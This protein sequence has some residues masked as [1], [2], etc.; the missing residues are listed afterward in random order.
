MKQRILSII[1]ALL[2]LSSASGQV[3]FSG[4]GL[5]PVIEVAPEASTGLNKIYVVYNTDG[6]GMTYTATSSDPVVWLSYDSHNW[7][8]PDTITDIRQDGLVTT[9]DQ[10]MPNRGYII[11]EGTAATC[12]WVVNYADYK[13]ELNDIIVNKDD[14][15]SLLSFTVDGH[16][17][18]IPYY[19]TDGRRQVL[20]REIELHYNTLVWDGLFAWYDDA[21]HS[22][23]EKEVVETFASL[24]EAITI[25][26]PLCGTEFAF[27]GDRF[28]LEWGLDEVIESEYYD[29]QAVACGTTATGDNIE[30][31][32]DDGQLG[33]PAPIS[34]TFT[35]YPTDA[36]ASGVWEMATDSDFEN[37]IM[38]FPQDEVT[39]RFT[40]VGIYYYMRY[41]VANA[42][43]SCK[44][45]SDTYTI[46]PRN[47]D[48]PGD[49]NGDY[50]VNLVDINATIDI[51]LGRGYYTTADV[52]CDGEIN[53]ADVNAIVKIILHN[54]Y[55]DVESEWVDLGLPSGT[56]WATCNIGANYPEESGDYFAWGETAP[57]EVYSWETYKWAY[58]DSDDEYV[59]TKYNYDSR[60]G[61]VDNKMVLDPEDDAAYV[62]LGPSWRMPSAEQIQELTRCCAWRWRSRD[63]VYGWLGTG[64]NGKNIFLPV[65]GYRDEDSLRHVGSYGYCWSSDIR[66]EYTPD[67]AHSLTFG[68]GPN[69]WDYEYG[70][71]GLMYDDRSFGFTIRPVRVGTE[72]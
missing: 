68:W 38:Q 65:T 59:L 28:L 25:D 3:A 64:P 31:G 22:W 44:A 52:N 57:K 32:F 55:V 19:A 60:Y 17:D 23:E 71:V 27:S 47:N 36:V 11:V 12:L 29:A 46:R 45:Y 10:V 13:L 72:P 61:T 6:V 67:C 9:L 53:I 43:G 37:V 62:I 39:Y 69:Y 2:A 66:P 58:I 33:G 18:A 51:I 14:P 16:G 50:Q 20:D 54:E 35:G 49:V 4:V 7:E 40:E 30:I 48:V 1:V 5:Y 42:D 26:P 41:V 63:D 15:C 21:W 24:D 70:F 8:K 34:I 56:L